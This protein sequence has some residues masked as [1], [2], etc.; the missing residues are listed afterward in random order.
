MKIYIVIKKSVYHYA[1]LN[2]IGILNFEENQ[3]WYTIDFFDGKPTD[4]I[5]WNNVK[6]YYDKYTKEEFKELYPELMI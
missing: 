6:D 4:F 1:N 2:E 3:V 5:D